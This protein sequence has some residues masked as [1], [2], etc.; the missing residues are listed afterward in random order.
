MNLKRRA[1]KTGN[2]KIEQIAVSYDFEKAAVR[3][4]MNKKED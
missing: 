3:D 4:E 2:L 1:N